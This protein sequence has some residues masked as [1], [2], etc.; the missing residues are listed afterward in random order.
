MMNFLKKS[1]K[2]KLTVASLAIALVPMIVIGVIA[3]GFSKNALN[4]QIT[5]DFDAIAAG[6]EEAVLQYLLGAKRAL[7]VYGHEPT[8]IRNLEILNSRSLEFAQAGKSIQD[9]IDERL[10][11]NPLIQEFLVMDKQGRVVASTEEKEL[12]LDKSQD[13]YFLG[14]RDKDFFIK[15]VYQSKTSGKI[16]FVASE[17]VK[18]LGTGEFVGVFAE[19]INLKMLNDIL[20]RRMGLGETGESYL[21][22]KDGLMLTESRFE[23][24]AAMNRRTE[25]AI[26][27]SFQANGKD[28]TGI[29]QDYR[30]QLVLG[31]VS[32]ELLKAEYDYLGWAVVAEMDTSEAFAPVNRLGEFVLAVMAVVAVIVVIIA[33]AISN[34]IALPI[35]TLS[36]AAGEVANGNLGVS[37]SVKSDDE[38]GLLAKSFE[39]MVISLRAILTKLQDTVAHMT[40]ASNEILAAAQEQASAAREQSSAVA[41]TTSAAKELSTTS[42]Q[43]GESIKKVAQ[44]AAHALAGM[45]K[46]K[47]TIDKT[48]GMLS[49]LGER[50]QKIG[51]I[52]E[53]IDDVAD[54]T[55]LLAV[56][57]SIEAARAGDQ[58]R[59]FT[60]VADEI[61]KL[62]DSTAKST[63]DITALIEMIQHEMSN[64]I[65]SMEQSVQS[66]DEEARLAQ[67]TTEKTKEIAMST[68]QQISGSKQIADA[69][70]NIDESMKQIAAGAQQ[71][72]ASVKQLNE[73]AGELKQLASKFKL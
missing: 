49:S 39:T 58:G 35:R 28:A 12:G 13:P 71:S 33:V 59:G 55:N 24:D 69:M 61:R 56:N 38:V 57:A 4:H 54:Q 70:M 27:K 68:H 5:Q 19:R 23:K 62:A 15:D 47:D 17:A 53:M 21:I 26:V 73:L 52:T 48:N 67:Q 25:T 29:Y 7:A 14:A 16:G 32:G 43:V 9:Y 72:Q 10:K 51:K 42:E 44:V 65:M 60:V 36:D 46:I 3:Y 41:E 2:T 40:A 31:S 11:V 18:N 66:V 50:S 8:L 1:I 20:G 30:K 37:F 63:K 6:K 22:N 34:N 64:A 45:G